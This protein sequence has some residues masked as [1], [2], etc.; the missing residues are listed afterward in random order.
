MIISSYLMK[1]YTAAT[2]LVASKKRPS[3]SFLKLQINQLILQYCSI[4]SFAYMMLALWTAVTFFLPLRCANS[5]AYLAIFRE[6]SL[7]TLLMD[8]ITPG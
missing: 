5:K 2:S 3:A 1:G 7:V 8:S 4:C 6:F